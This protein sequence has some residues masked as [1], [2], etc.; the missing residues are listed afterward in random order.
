MSPIT[1]STWSTRWPDVSILT[2]VG[3]RPQFVKAAAVSRVLR[4]EREEILVHT[5]QHYDELLSDVFFDELPV[6]EPDYNLG[7]GSDS[8]GKQTAA[9]IEGIEPLVIEH[10]PD[11]ILLYGDTNS[12]LAGAIVGSKC[13]VT[14]AHVEAGLRSFNREMP[15]ETNRVVTDHISDVCLA[16]TERAVS[17]LAAEG[18]T[19]GVHNSGDVMYDMVQWA[20]EHAK[21]HSQI[22]ETL[23]LEQ[24]SYV[25]TT[26]HRAENTD[27]PNRLRGIVDGLLTASQPVVFPAHPRVTD[28]LRRHGLW[29]KANEAF[30][31]I[32]PVGYLDFIHL[33]EGADQVATDSGGVQKEAFFVDTPCVTLRDETEWVETIDCG[34]NQLV[35]ADR[36]AIARALT[37][38]RLL[39]E[40]PTPYG[41]GNAAENIV[42]I[43]DSVE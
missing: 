33:L 36:D 29:E 41:D 31:F 10:K 37:E 22:L 18:I 24:E 23:N 32:E 1:S 7:V 14:V 34:W 5:G 38:E 39:E 25:L 20:N 11:V 17:N 3:A 43:L 15:E 2:V 21:N 30:Q 27:D 42:G 4:P 6:P 26:V 13:D 12:T 16:P 35:G 8:H 19:D 28:R 9:M 40:K